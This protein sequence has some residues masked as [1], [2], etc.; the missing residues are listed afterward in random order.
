MH[1]VPTQR[2]LEKGESVD[3]HLSYSVSKTTFSYFFKNLVHF[4]PDLV[5]APAAGDNRFYV[6]NNKTKVKG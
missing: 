2:K 4:T 5:A 6:H 3:R 1:S